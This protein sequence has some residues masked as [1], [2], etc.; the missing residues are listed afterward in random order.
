MTTRLFLALA[1]AL[2]IVRLPA[3]VQPMGADQGLYAYV[4]E[5]ILDGGLPY[6]DAWDQKP[7]AVHFT[8]AA[9]RA[10][11]PHDSAVAIADLAAAVLTAW[12]L[13]RLGGVLVAPRTG[14]VAALLFLFLANPAFARLAGVSVRAQSETFIAV[15]VTGALLLLLRPGAS[16]WRIAAAGVLFG[17]AFTF[18]Y[19]MV[20]YAAAGTLMLFLMPRKGDDVRRAAPVFVALGFMIPVSVVAALFAVRGAL[21]D[22]YDATITYNV[23]YAGETY[24]GPLDAIRY[25]LTFPIERARVD[26]LWLIGGAGCAVLMGASLRSRDR[27]IAPVWVA[28]ACLAIA[29]NSS[30]GLPQYFVQAGPALALAAA[31]AATLL[32]S[33][34]TVVNVAVVVLVSYAVWRVNNFQKLAENTWHDTQYVARQTTKPQHLARYGEPNVRKYSALAVENLAE[35]LRVHSAE[36]ETVYIFGFSAGAY[37][38]ADRVSASRFFWSRPVIAG[39]ND[40]V[41]GYGA[42]GLL[43]DLTRNTPKV[44]A[45]QQVDWLRDVD[46]SSHFFTTHPQLG[47]W[48]RAHYA[49]APGPEGFDIWLRQGAK[50]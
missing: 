6:K 37:V 19:N 8:Y 43:A 23:Q 1:G 35:Y 48:L 44:I 16:P 45:L 41:P 5:R 7:P 36:G 25:L 47:P 24:A 31:W 14:Q 33:R 22:L 20:V 32:W 40:G 15:T 39:F 38:K 21:P 28:A 49:P 46:N 29:I 34:R 30:R 2:I 12:L 11:W 27:M 3:L 10:M 17:I 18:K 42:G 4:G 50:P 26:G 9:L 13:Y